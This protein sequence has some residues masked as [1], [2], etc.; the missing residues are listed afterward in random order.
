MKHDYNPNRMIGIPLG[1]KNG[2]YLLFL[3][4]ALKLLLVHLYPGEEMIKME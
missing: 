3:L 4:E 1:Y 2:P